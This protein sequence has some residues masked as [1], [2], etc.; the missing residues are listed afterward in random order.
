MLLALGGVLYTVGAIGLGT[1]W[2][3]PFPAT[4]GYHEIWHILVVTACACHFAVVLS[5]VRAG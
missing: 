1:R 4:F 5:L 2:P 3:D